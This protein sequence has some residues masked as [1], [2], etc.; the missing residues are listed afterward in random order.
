MLK[1][2]KRIFKHRWIDE[3]AAVPPDML[4]RLTQRIQMSEL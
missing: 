3:Q 4:T 1:Q 2:L